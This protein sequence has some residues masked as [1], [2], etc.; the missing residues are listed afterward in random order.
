[1]S[2]TALLRELRQTTDP[3]TACALA[4]QLLATSKRR[5]VIDAALYTLEQHPLDDSARPALRQRAWHYFEHPREDAGAL[6]REKLLRLL[7]GVNHPDDRDLYLRA[8]TTY[9]IVPFMGEVTQ[10]L[11]AV[12]LVGLAIH[13]PELGVIHATRL[14]CELEATSKFNGE[15]AL[16]AV[17]LLRERGQTAP[18]YSYLLLEG[19][20]AHSEVV[21]LALESLGP[22]F[23]AALYQELSA[24]FVPLDRAV[25]SMGIVTHICENHVRDL[26]PLVDE[27][28]TSTRHDELHRYAVLLLA[29]SRDPEQINRL[30]ALAK[31]SP[32]YRCANFIEA[33]ELIPGETHGELLGWLAAHSASSQR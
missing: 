8:L 32:P 4:L 16:T 3:A 6:I 24:P 17:N 2:Q 30:R 14:L 23:P 10:N 18:I 31:L 22:D 12:G 20:E 5:E 29:A 7:I 11:R 13:E 28:I 27:I 33:L 1:M 19:L 26:Y 25:V 9:E 21:G 15:P